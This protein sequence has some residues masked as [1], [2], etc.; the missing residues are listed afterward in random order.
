MNMHENGAH[1][2]GGYA[3]NEEKSEVRAATAIRK[4]E[5]REA[6]SATENDVERNPRLLCA[7]QRV[8]LCGCILD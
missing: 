2:G 7:N 3:G 4:G 5:S 8:N 6:S 1:L